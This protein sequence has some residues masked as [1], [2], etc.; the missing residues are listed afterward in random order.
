MREDLAIN[1]AG[2]MLVFEIRIKVNF[3]DF[4]LEFKE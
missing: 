2:I 3:V 1:I 4:L